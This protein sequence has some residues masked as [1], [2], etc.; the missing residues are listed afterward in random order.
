MHRTNMSELLGE[1]AVLL[2]V[3]AHKT[4]TGFGS[5]PATGWR[6][7]LMNHQTGSLDFKHHLH[8]YIKFKHHVTTTE[9]PQWS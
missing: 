5:G 9:S 1:A 3:Q 7:T 4:P 6:V 2:S 8:K